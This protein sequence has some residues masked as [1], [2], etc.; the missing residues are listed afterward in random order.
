MKRLRSCGCLPIPL[1][2]PAD[3]HLLRQRGERAVYQPCPCLRDRRDAVEIKMGAGL[4]VPCSSVCVRLWEVE[5]VSTTE[6][7]ISPCM[8]TL[9]GDIGASALTP[10]HGPPGSHSFRLFC[11]CSVYSELL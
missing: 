10:G 11:K 9:Q 8:G 4:G 1:P 5:V 2:D 7:P 6:A 3:H